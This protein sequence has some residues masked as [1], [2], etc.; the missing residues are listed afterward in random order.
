[1]KGFAQIDQLL[2]GATDSGV[3]PGVIAVIASRDEVLYQGAAGVRALGQ[4]APMTVDTVAWIASMTKAVTAAAAMQCVERELLTLDDA[5]A[6]WL[7]E[8]DQIKL[9]EGFDAAGKPLLRAPRR[10]LTLRNL[11]THTA[12]FGYEFLSAETARYLEAQHVPGV[13]SGSRA[14]LMRPLIAEPDSHWEYGIGIDWA[15]RLVEEVSGL[16]LG[17]Y[18]RKHLFEPLGMKTTSFKL[19]PAH[20]EKLAGV[21]ARLPDGTLVPYPF[22]LPQ[23]AELDMGGHGLYSTLPDYMRFLRMILNGGTLDGQTVLARRTVE[24]MTQNQIGSLQVPAQIK[25][26]NPQLCNDIVFPP[27]NPSTWG[28]SFM[29]N[30]KR[31]PEGRSAGSLSWAGL[32]NSYY[33][34]DPSKGVAGVLLTQILPFFDMHVLKLLSEVE[35]RTYQSLR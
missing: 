4:P 14:T 5:A 33:W 16:R 22:E 26:V 25:T 6:R 21:H 19:T 35:T 29:I 27:D 10:V 17:D 9:L 12:G 1:M 32:A 34:I 8:L 3:I 28:L 18:M 24:R 20:R 30:G 31:T 23:D 13:I 15:G 2:K 11:L 7:P